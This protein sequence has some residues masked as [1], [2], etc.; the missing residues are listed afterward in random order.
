MY[1]YISQTVHYN[2][3]NDLSAMTKPTLNMI[4]VEGRKGISMKANPMPTSE[5]P[6]WIERYMY[7]VLAINY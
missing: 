1:V 7:R 4:P 3:W 2:K 6:L 5:Y